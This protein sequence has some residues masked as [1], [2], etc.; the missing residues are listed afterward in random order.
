LSISFHILLYSESV[1]FSTGWKE[2][3]SPPLAADDVSAG[4]EMMLRHFAPQ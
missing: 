1:N 4:A 3:M 2:M